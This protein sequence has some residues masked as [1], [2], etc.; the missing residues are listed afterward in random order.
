MT[1]YLFKSIFL[2]VLFLI[3]FCSFA[4]EE[5]LIPVKKLNRDF[6]KFL[7]FM[8]A[9]PEPYRVI[10]EKHFNEIIDS[11]KKEIQKPLSVEDFYKC[12]TNIVSKIEDGHTSI[13]MP[14]NWILEKRKKSGAFPYVV[15]LNNEGELFFIKSYSSANN[16]PLGSKIHSINKLSIEEII[17]TIDPWVSYERT[18]F[19]NVAIERNF[20]TY[21]RLIFGDIS[22]LEISYNNPEL[23]SEQIEL[24]E[25]KE[26]K[27]QIKDNR[28]DKEK[29]LLAGEPYEYTKLTE[30]IGLISIYSFSVSDFDNFN[31]F[32][33]KSFKK[34]EKDSIQSLILDVR[35]NFG[36]FPKCS[37]RIIHNMSE[38]Y[39][40]NMARS[41]LKA[42]LTFKDYLQRKLEILKYY[43]G[44]LRRGQHSLNINEVLGKPDNT[45][46]IE[47]DFHNEPP[48]KYDHEFTGDLYLL[49]DRSS[50]SA[51]SLFAATF[52]CY[53]LG[54]IIGEQT[55]GT[56]IFYGNP[57]G[58]ALPHSAIYFNCAT[59][60]IFATCYNEHNEGITP[61]IEV[62]QSIFQRIKDYDNQLN[63]AVRI[64]KKINKES[65]N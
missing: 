16:I 57:I 37:S 6:K 26:Y 21:L 65:Q 23:M 18:E 46:I 24:L 59:T 14:Q 27:N 38:K 56:K 64:I 43:N 47:D 51:S 32:V 44:F 1:S 10:G 61:D 60:K 11:T 19:R 35:G 55:G 39:F 4:Q 8:E 12:L 53:S 45:M 62:G 22:E 41:E 13:S 31:Y 9:H 33:G 54:L 15:H 36:G 52:K 63:Y 20:E 3:P 29:K 48:L 5:E 34:I 40:K 28:K 58:E 2:C 42:S 50:Y 30:N 25:Y 17:K 49:T 7:L